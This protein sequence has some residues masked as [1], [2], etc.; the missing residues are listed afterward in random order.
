MIS[1]GLHDHA[2]TVEVISYTSLHTWYYVGH[3]A[4]NSLTTALKAQ[5]SVTI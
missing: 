4:D 3:F 2:I 1:G 5:A